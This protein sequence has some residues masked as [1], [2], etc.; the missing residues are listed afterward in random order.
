MVPATYKMHNLERVILMQQGLR[1]VSSA[2][3]RPV[4]FNRDLFGLE[5]EE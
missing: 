2:H 4:K 3:Y 1:P 5:L